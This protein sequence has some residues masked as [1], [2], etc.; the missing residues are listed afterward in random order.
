MKP[1]KPFDGF[2]LF[3]AF[4]GCGARVHRFRSFQIV[5]LEGVSPRELKEAAQ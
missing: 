5:G 1:G 4:R 3:K 2:Q